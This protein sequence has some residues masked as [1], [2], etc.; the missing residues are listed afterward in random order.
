MLILLSQLIFLTSPV[1]AAVDCAKDPGTRITLDKNSIPMSLDPKILEFT[2]INGGMAR[3]LQGKQVVFQEDHWFGIQKIQT[4]KSS[5]ISG[6]KF[7]IELNKNT[8]KEIRKHEGELFIFGETDPL[9]SLSYEIDPEKQC[10]FDQAYL[11]RNPIQPNGQITI[12]FKGYADRRYQLVRGSSNSRPS[13]KLAQTTTDSN[14]DGSFENVTIEGVNGETVKLLLDIND[15]KTPYQSCNPTIRLSSSAGTPAPA[16]SSTIPDKVAVKKCEKGDPSCS[17]GGGLPCGDASVESGGILTAIGCI[18]TNPASFTQDLV[19]FAVGISGGLAF[20][21]MLLGA[22]QM[23]TSNGNPD[24]LK[25]GQ[26]RLI[27]ATIGL[28]IVIFAVLLMQIIGVD[29]LKLPG[30]VR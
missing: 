23:L 22:S 27:S 19:K 4:G 7:S 10:R 20:L 6:N 29:I 15:R 14:G 16:D 17:G 12:K 25:A 21:M 13:A 2:V 24:A 8:L 11:D 9:C 18:H 3:E 1:S 26:D 5:P 30:F 28:L